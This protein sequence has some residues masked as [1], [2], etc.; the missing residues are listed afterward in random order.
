MAW[1]IYLFRVVNDLAGRGG[2]VDALGVFAAVFLLPLLVFLLIPAAFTIKR[3]REEHW[4]ELPVKALVSGFIAYMIQWIVGTAVGRARPFAA[5]ADVHQ[6]ISKDYVYDSFPSGHASVAFA[7]A[8][9]VFYHDKDWGAAFLALAALVALGR[10]F[11]GV[12]YPLDIL[13]GA[14]VGWIAAWCVHWLERREWGKITRGLR[15][16]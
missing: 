13:A 11:A 1:D 14:G 3:L 4:Y 8:F 15:V 7:I 2:G 6:L 10:V 12:H 5:L 16:R 9:A